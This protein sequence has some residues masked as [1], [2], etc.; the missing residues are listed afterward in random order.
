MK[1]ETPVKIRPSAGSI[2]LWLNK[3]PIGERENV[4]VN[5]IDKQKFY[6]VAR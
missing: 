5:G 1:I 3:D 4:S 2:F 6:L